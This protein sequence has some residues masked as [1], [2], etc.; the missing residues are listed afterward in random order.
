MHTLMP[1]RMH[2]H[3]LIYTSIQ[4]NRQDKTKHRHQHLIPTLLFR[5]LVSGM[6][7][8][9]IFFKVVLKIELSF[10]GT[11]TFCLGRPTYH[12]SHHEVVKIS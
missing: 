7:L 8:F 10:A 4:A 12:S 5:C 3:I 9:L 1:T 6:S 2:T 11:Q